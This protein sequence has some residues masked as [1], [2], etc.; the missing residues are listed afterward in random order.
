V[1]RAEPGVG[2]HVRLPVGLLTIIIVSLL[3]PPS[4]EVQELVEHVRYPHLRG[5]TVVSEAR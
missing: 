5:D 4:K 1:V 2:R 3:T